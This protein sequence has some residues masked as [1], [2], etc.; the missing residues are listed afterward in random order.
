MAFFQRTGLFAL[1]ACSAS[2]CLLGG[3]AADA[4]AVTLENATMSLDY[5]GKQPVS[6]PSRRSF[7]A[8]RDA[9]SANLDPYDE[10]G[11]GAYLDVHAAAPGG[12]DFEVSFGSGPNDRLLPGV[13]K[14]GP[15][16]W[17]YPGEACG[18]GGYEI[19]HLDYSLDGSIQRAWILFQARCRVD[20]TLF[21]EIRIGMDDPEAAELVSPATMRWPDVDAGRAGGPHRV[22]YL[23]RTGAILENARLTGRD[24][25][26]FA[27]E[28]DECGG[29]L[30]PAGSRC[31]VSVRF[32]GASP[33]YRLANLEIPS[34]GGRVAVSSLEAFAHGGR[35]RME[36]HANS[37]GMF[38][39]ETDWSLEPSRG[40]FSPW[41][42]EE[43]GTQYLSLD[44]DGAGGDSFNFEFV[45]GEEEP[46]A[47]GDHFV[48]D[49]PRHDGRPSLEIGGNGRGCEVPK[50]EFTI[51]DFTEDFQGDTTSFGAT[52]LFRCG[53]RQATG[54]I[55]WRAGDESEQPP[56]LEWNTDLEPPTAAVIEHPPPELLP[57]VP[58]LRWS[59]ASDPSGIHHYELELNGELVTKDIPGDA[60]SYSPVTGYGDGFN[61]WELIAV[62]NRGNG[63]VTAEHRFWLD[64]HGPR[65]SLHK[66]YE[67]YPAPARPTF[68]WTADDIVGVAALEL[69]IDGQ[70]AEPLDPEGWKHLLSFDLT[71]GSHTWQIR[72]TDLFG[73]QS[74]SDPAT[75][76]VDATAPEPFGVVAPDDE[77]L[78]TARPRWEWEPA[79]DL[80]SGMLRYEVW[81][82][83]RQLG[84]NVLPSKTTF[85][86][87]GYLPEGRHEW[88]I[89]AVDR[90][91][92]RRASEVRHFMVDDHPP[93][94]F[95][96]AYPV[97]GEIKGERR[98]LLA[99]LPTTDPGRGLDRYEI[100]IDGIRVGSAPPEHYI[101]VPPSDLPEGRHTWRVDAV[102]NSGR[103]T[104]G[105]GQGI[106]TVDVTPP[107]PFQPLTPRQSEVVGATPVLT[108]QRAGDAVSTVETYVIEID[109][110]QTTL[111][112][113]AGQ[114]VPGPLAPGEH[115]WKV[116]AVDA[117]GNQTSTAP[118]S[119]TV[120]DARATAPPASQERTTPKARR[121]RCRAIRLKPQR[122]KCMR[123]VRS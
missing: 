108:W 1:L 65:I 11:P 14:N 4:E 76:Y 35:T 83:G 58:E 2:V 63:V 18:G 46:L 94:G 99:W 114:L 106:F 101:F 59:P 34:V 28:A 13:Y 60:T 40:T 9:M 43:D 96:L 89:V 26:H 85:D 57:A 15:Q 29:H 67:G 107:R 53:I 97:D 98:P 61:Y 3:G 95:R 39:L 70:D 33:G 22:T 92:N 51:T 84:R 10:S 81:V 73:H 78:Q 12:E 52:F 31:T 93:L 64:T 120:R 88:Q 104:T 74:I 48:D 117:G 21:G 100:S 62:D 7:D 20:S 47:A 19:K 17:P 5:H 54:L 6:A 77:S 41:V 111:P 90:A 102:G 121:A 123:R 110:A 80:L 79:T 42:Y 69:V 8:S 16:V 112:G 37:E 38:G 36:M 71:E 56:W 44:E 49:N 118:L 72:G 87:P 75:F 68:E 119:F 30:V 55:E 116:T 25:E 45:G 86:S 91:G 32:K 115:W 103:V 82:D 66:P 113:D 27:I 109:G 24:A 23:S 122:R 50:G 105:E